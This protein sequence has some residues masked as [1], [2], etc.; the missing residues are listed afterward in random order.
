VFVRIYHHCHISLVFSSGMYFVA[1]AIHGSY[2]FIY[3]LWK[4]LS[5]VLLVIAVDGRYFQIPPY[6]I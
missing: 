6:H 5:Y 1:F 4:I 2:F 3:E